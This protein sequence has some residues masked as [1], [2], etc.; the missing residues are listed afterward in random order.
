MV[1]YGRDTTRLNILP[2][3]WKY[4]VEELREEIDVLA[5]KYDL[6][7]FTVI[8]AKEK[9]G[10]MTIYVD[11]VTEEALDEWLALEQKYAELSLNTCLSC[12]RTTTRRKGYALCAECAARYD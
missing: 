4:L 11:Q 1:Y 3:G 6:T 2:P 9:W 10:R 12:G 7:F 8:D 5:D